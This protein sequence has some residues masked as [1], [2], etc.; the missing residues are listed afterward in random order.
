MR[1]GCLL[2]PTPTSKVD[3][4]PSAS[5]NTCTGP[6][7]WLL[8]ICG[9]VHTLMTACLHVMIWLGPGQTAPKIMGQRGCPHQKGGSGWSG[10]PGSLYTHK[11]ARG[12]VSVGRWGEVVLPE[13]SLQSAAILPDYTLLHFDLQ[14]TRGKHVPSPRA[15]PTCLGVRGRQTGSRGHT[16]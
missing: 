8:E 3:T 14:Q 6:V 11:D 12:A 16:T 13:Y 10:I 15:S 2:L 7:C 5:T 9:L 4:A 1:A